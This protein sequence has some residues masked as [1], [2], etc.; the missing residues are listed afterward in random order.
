MVLARLKR[1]PFADLDLGP[2]DGLQVTHCLIV[3]TGPRGRSQ[4]HVI[5]RRF[6]GQH[7]LKTSNTMSKRKLLQNTGMTG[8]NS[9]GKADLIAGAQGCQFGK[10]PTPVSFCFNDPDEYELATTARARAVYNPCDSALL[11]VCWQPGAKPFTELGT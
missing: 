1:E 7:L 3:K 11:V 5:R 10:D 9:H 4:L 8:S 2:E 6:K